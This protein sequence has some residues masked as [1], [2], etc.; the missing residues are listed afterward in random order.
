MVRAVHTKSTS[1]R[2]HRLAAG[3]ITT[4]IRYKTTPQFDDQVQG[5][6]VRRMQ[7]EHP[8]L[9][10]SW[11]SSGMATID[12]ALDVT[13]R[14]RSRPTPEQRAQQ[15]LDNHVIRDDWKRDGAQIR[16]LLIEAIELERS[17]Q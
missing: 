7:S 1:G 14:D 4:T 16:K 8:T 17:E 9:A 15:V 13:E 12:T 5:D 2:T 11:P 3:D 10:L 6:L